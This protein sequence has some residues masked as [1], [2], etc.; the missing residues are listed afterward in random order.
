MIVRS[1]IQPR[2]IF[3]GL[4]KRGILIRDVTGYPMLQD[5]FRVGVGTPEE[6]NL[7]LK[8]LREIFAA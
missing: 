7:L 4:L 1:A 2:R 5:Y 8:S 6:N 3:E